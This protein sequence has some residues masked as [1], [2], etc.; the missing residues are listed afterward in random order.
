MSVSVKN[1]SKKYKNFPAVSDVSFECGEGRITGIL[2]P[3]GAGKTTILKAISARHIPTSGDIFVDGKSVLDETESVR[4]L[5]GF[6][7]EEP[8]LPLEYKVFEYLD[9]VLQLHSPQ[10]PAVKKKLEQELYE[11]LSLKELMNKKIKRLSKGQRQRVNFA[12]AL[13]FSP[14]VLIL[15][16]PASGL[17][18]SQ[19]I[20][21]RSFVKSLRKNRTIIISTHIMQEAQALCDDILILSHGKIAAS[22]T[23]SQITGATNS[24]SL[25][26]AFFRLTQTDQ[27]VKS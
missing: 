16:E 11:N 8:E 2:G 9:S 7:T 18:P 19:I 14:S 3:N 26:E 10:N 6:V 15:D 21:M 5:T 24:K 17:D 13:I 12:Q 25:E 4:N 23:V 27:E 20:K 1:F 22:G